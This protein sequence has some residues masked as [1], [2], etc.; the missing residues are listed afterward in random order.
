MAGRNFKINQIANGMPQVDDVLEGWMV[1]FIANFMQQ[2]RIDGE[3]IER[4]TFVKMEGVLQPLKTEDINLKP[5]GQRNWKWYQLHVP[6]KYRQ[7][8]VGKV[9]VIGDTDY[10]IMASKD[11][12]LNSYV[13]YHIIKDYEGIE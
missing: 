5:E 4:S 9:V 12:T 1:S 7:I 13:E 8:P 3:F 11:Y 6:I 10:K 2:V